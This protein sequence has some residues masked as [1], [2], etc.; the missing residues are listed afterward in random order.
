LPLSFL[1][2]TVALLITCDDELKSQ[3]RDGVYRYA[4]HPAGGAPPHDEKPDSE[5]GY[6]NEVRVTKLPVSR[7]DRVTKVTPNEVRVTPATSPARAL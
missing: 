6:P 7:S 5:Q 2:V 4:P 3:L 1:K